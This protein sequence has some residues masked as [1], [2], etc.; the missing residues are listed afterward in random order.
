M[1]DSNCLIR[2][3]VIFMIMMMT[4]AAGSSEELFHS[5]LWLR[6]E[7]VK[8]SLRGLSTPFWVWQGS[9]WKWPDPRS[10]P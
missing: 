3:T 2:G 6:K 5:I 4:R 7:T 1:L 8:M 10:I 9:P